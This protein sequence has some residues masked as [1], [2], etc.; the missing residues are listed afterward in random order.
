MRHA[1]R[2][3]SIVRKYCDSRYNMYHV[4]SARQCRHQSS[5]ALTS[6]TFDKHFDTPHLSG[7]TQCGRVGVWML[8]CQSLGKGCDPNN[9]H[10]FTRAEWGESSDGLQTD[11]SSQIWWSFLLLMCLGVS[12]KGNID[13]GVLSSV[14]ACAA[15]HKVSCGVYLQ[16][17]TRTDEPIQVHIS[18]H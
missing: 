1:R 13:L 7:P 10:D 3:V 12:P 14:G 5:I 4:E 8:F 15:G 18:T 2:I 17:V 11:L 16:M 9:V 6:I